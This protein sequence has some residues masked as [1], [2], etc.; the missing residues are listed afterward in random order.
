[1]TKPLVYQ[2]Q[3][4]IS[5]FASRQR[6]QIQWRIVYTNGFEGSLAESWTVDLARR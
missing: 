6:T 1:M 2:F 4:K 5:V 3:N